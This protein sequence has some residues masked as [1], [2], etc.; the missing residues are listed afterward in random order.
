MSD[1]QHVWE[2]PDQRFPWQG[3]CRKC[4]AITTVA[5][6]HYLRRREDQRDRAVVSLERQLA[7]SAETIRT[8][9]LELRRLREAMAELEAELQHQAGEA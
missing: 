2:I 1:C 8:Q 4:G 6:A 9:E 5:Q 7:A 3:E